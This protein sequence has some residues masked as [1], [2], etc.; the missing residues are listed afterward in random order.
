MI[1]WSGAAFE[2]RVACGAVEHLMAADLSRPAQSWRCRK[3]PS[4]GPAIGQLKDFFSGQAVMTLI[5]A[6]FV[7]LFSCS[8]RL[9]GPGSLALVPIAVIVVFGTMVAFSGFKLSRCLERRGD[10]DNLRYD[11]SSGKPCTASTRSRAMALEP[12][13]LR[14]YEAFEASLVRS[15]PRG[16]EKPLRIW[17][18]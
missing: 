8:C 12:L 1:G 15:E 4:H 18:I 17:S 7:F 6:C 14:R 11:F 16:H 10:A 2:H 13:F 9:R 3:R 5:E